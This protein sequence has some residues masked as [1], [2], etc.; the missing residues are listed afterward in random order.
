[1]GQR[2][3]KEDEYY[4]FKPFR[5]TKLNPTTYNLVNTNVK[6]PKPRSGHRIVCDSANLYSF[7]GYLPLISSYELT[8]DDD[9]L[10]HRPLFREIW[11]FNFATLTWSKIPCKEFPEVLV[12]NAVTLNG[13][14]LMI[15]GGTSYPFGTTCSNDLY[16]CNLSKEDPVIQRVPTT[17]RIP[18]PQYGQSIVIHEDNLYTFGGTTGYEYTSDL[19]RL[20]LKNRIW[21]GA[22]INKGLENEPPGMYRH[23]IVLFE[24]KIYVFGGGKV[25]RAYGFENIYAYSLHSN[26]WEIHATQ[27]DPVAALDGL[28]GYPKKRYCHSCIQLPDSP[29]QIAILGGFD[30]ANV[31]EDVWM[32]NLLN[33]QWTKIINCNLPKIYFHSSSVLTSGK[34]VTF[35]GIIQSNNSRERTSDIY[36]AWLCI[37]KLKEMCWDAILFYSYSN[38]YSASELH[39]MGVPLGYIQRI[40]SGSNNL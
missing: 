10:P 17:G 12:S 5:M 39:S 38:K 2:N 30:G 28:G 26:Q 3:A 8:S 1:M 40:Y 35:G 16:L 23:E 9:W 37:P 15:F 18:L 25:N 31:F 24:S 19:H 11:K 29:N 34:V 20:N 21:D 22:Y 7:G 4:S 14:I 36:V 27:Q 13:E 33:F 32:L 6:I